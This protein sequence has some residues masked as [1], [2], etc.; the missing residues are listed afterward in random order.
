[1]P[2]ILRRHP[3][4]TLWL[5]GEGE[6]RPVLESAA[7]DLGI[8]AHVRFLGRLGNDIIWKYYAAADL[9][10]LPSDVESWG[11]VMLESMACG[12][13][14]VTTDTVGGLEVAGLFPDDVTVVP[15]ASAGSLADAV[16]Q[17]LRV[18]KRVSLPALH[19]VKND[20]TVAACA[21]QYLRVYKEAL[22]LRR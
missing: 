7:R 22:S 8:A 12:T 11:T 20:F 1:M 21:A 17:F 18:P 16:S 10:V 6:L 14:V 5:A 9:F 4:V 3:N 15:R 19:R 13:P 2:D